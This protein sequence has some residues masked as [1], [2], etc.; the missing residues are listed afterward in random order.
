MSNPFIHMISEYECKGLSKDFLGTMEQSDKS[1]IKD[2]FLIDLLVVS[3]LNQ[4][5]IYW[6]GEGFKI[7]CFFLD[8]QERSYQDIF[9]GK[10]EF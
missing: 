10:E 3:Q 6:K 9:E 5:F 7:D 4:A 8:F 1:P 2:D